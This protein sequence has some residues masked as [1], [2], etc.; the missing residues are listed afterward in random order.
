MS[1]ATKY[2]SDP[3]TASSVNHLDLVREKGDGSRTRV[4]RF[5]RRHHPLGE[6]PH[7]VAAWSARYQDCIVAVVVLNRPARMVDDT[8]EINI[9][10]LARRGDRPSNTCSWLI[11]RAR[12]WA[13]LEGYQR[14]AAHAGVAGNYGTAYEAAGFECVDVT[15]ADGKGWQSRE[16]RESWDDY[17]RRKWVDEIGGASDD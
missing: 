10:R 7:W 12:V 1:D 6:V 15:M 17:E 8:E 16:G 3:P 5:L 9:Q 14:I 2:V 4:N 11:A 13:R